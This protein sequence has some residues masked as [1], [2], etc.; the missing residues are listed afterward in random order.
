MFTDPDVWPVGSLKA[1]LGRKQ[2]ESLAVGAKPHQMRIATP[3]H[4]LEWG[5]RGQD[6]SKCPH[7]WN[8]DAEVLGPVSLFY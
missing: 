5:R 3:V 8:M 4:H 7:S 1:H 6:P 2:G